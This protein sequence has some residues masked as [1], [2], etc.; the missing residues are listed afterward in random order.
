MPFG[1]GSLIGGIFGAASQAS[2]N[3]AIAR[4]NE[5][6][7]Q[8]SHNEAILAHNRQLSIM[9]K[10]NEW[11][12]PENQRKL[13]QQAGY[14]PN[15]LMGS[16]GTGSIS[17]GASGGAQASAPGAGYPSPL[18]DP[19]MISAFADA[20][21]KESQAKNTDADTEKKNSETRGQEFDNAFKEMQNKVYKEFGRFQAMYDLDKTHSEIALNDAER[22]FTGIRERLARDELFTL[23]PK[24]AGNLIA[25][26]VNKES[27]TLL[28][29]ALAAKTD[30]ERN[31]L[32]KQYILASKLNAATCANLYAQA[33]ATRAQGDLWQPDTTP[34]SPKGL[35][36]RT[37]VN[38]L[39]LGYFQKQKAYRIYSEVMDDWVSTTKLSLKANG[40]HNAKVYNILSDPYSGN[41][42]FDLGQAAKIIPGSSSM[43]EPVSPSPL[44]W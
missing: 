23:R 17:S 4:E 33:Y 19:S 41:F 13:L 39:S 3:R 35:L 2:N 36:Y 32:F 37:S 8:F 18:L 1:I 10:Q 42:A 25:D 27:S 26:T 12:T 11:N 44:S 20:K 28:N 15:S 34:G 22:V 30:Q 6:Q 9:D 14:N 7:R 29:K 31:L 16:L 21:L 24:Q 5:K 38:N 40:I 43:F